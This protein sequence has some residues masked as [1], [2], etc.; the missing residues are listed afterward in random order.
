MTIVG[1]RMAALVIHPGRR[2][3]KEQQERRIHSAPLE[4]LP[5][6]KPH[7]QGYHLVGLRPGIANRPTF[8][9]NAAPEGTLASSSTTGITSNAGNQNERLASDF[10]WRYDPRFHFSGPLCAQSV[11]LLCLRAGYLRKSL[12][13]S[14]LRRD[15]VWQFPEFLVVC[16]RPLSLS[17]V[18]SSC[19]KPSH[20]VWEKPFRLSGE[21]ERLPKVTSTT[22]CS[23][24]ARPFWRPTL[25]TMW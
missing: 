6:F 21:P 11:L 19:L 12:L 4:L 13:N 16:C 9:A 8:P 24:S 7:S 20:R 17:S 15:V 5:D 14:S 2:C 3:L 23:R 22:E 25:R 1:Q 10:G 18:R